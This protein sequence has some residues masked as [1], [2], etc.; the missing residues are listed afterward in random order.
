MIGSAY[1]T[2]HDFAQLKLMFGPFDDAALVFIC[3]GENENGGDSDR[4]ATKNFARRFIV[5]SNFA[6]AP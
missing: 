4:L 5:A 6:N 3:P 1:A 2:V